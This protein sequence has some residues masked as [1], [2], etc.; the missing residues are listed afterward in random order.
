[1]LANQ[2]ER[3]EDWVKA[4]HYQ[5]RTAEKVKEQHAYQN[6]VQL[7][8]RALALAANVQ[9]LDEER[10]RG[11]VMLGDLWSLLGDVEKANQCYKQAMETT[12]DTTVWQQ[13]ANKCHQLHT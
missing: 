3:G 1:M 5:L 7:R 8:T 4:V 13:I 10:I 2:F 11:G 6:A 9:V 12:P